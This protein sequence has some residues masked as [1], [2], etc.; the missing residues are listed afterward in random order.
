MMS[1]NRVVAAATAVLSLTLAVLPVVVD[2]DWTSTAGV[3]AGIVAV[4]SVALK[5]LAG[6]QAHEQ[7]QAIIDYPHV[8]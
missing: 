4:V 5:W 7:R 8:Q 2:M 6:W 3:L 1:P